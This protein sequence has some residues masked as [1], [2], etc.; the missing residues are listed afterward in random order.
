MQSFYIVSAQY[1]MLWQWNHFVYVRL[2]CLG[3]AHALAQMPDIAEGLIYV[4]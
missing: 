2:A 1:A 4:F 3:C